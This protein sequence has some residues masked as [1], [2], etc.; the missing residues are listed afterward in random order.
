M[1]YTPPKDGRASFRK[2]TVQVSRSNGVKLRVS[3]RPGY[4]AGDPAWVPEDPNDCHRKDVDFFE[5]TISVRKGKTPGSNR[6]IPPI[7]RIYVGTREGKR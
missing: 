7:I 2:I 6:E 1:G 5:K 4:F 3:T